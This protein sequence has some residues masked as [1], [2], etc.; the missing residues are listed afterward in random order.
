MEDIQF[1]SCTDLSILQDRK[2]AVLDE[3]LLVADILKLL[4]YFLF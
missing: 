1:V 2:K 3:H 4:G